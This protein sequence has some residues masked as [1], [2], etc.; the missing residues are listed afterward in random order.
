MM[1]RARDERG[2]AAVAGLLFTLILLVL[3]A[4]I[5]DVYRIQDVRTFAYSAANDAA[6]RGASLGRDW[7]RFTATGEMYLDPYAANDAAQTALEQ[8]MH[9]RGITNFQYVVGVMPNP[10]GGTF[11]LP[12]PCLP[13]ASFWNT[14]TWTE[15]EPA[16]G[17]CTV[18]TVPTILFGLVNGNQPIAVNAFAAAGVAHQ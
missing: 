17:V 6:L 2:S 4:A 12:A 18:V 7:D 5:V 9:A 11:T 1:R 13:R 15:T 8:I 10:G 3:A 14:T 16:V